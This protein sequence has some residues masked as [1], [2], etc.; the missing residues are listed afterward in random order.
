M[1]LTS[2]SFHSWEEDF[3][4]AGFSRIAGVDEVGRGCLAGPVIAASVILPLDQRI[5]GVRDSK[6]L[7]PKKRES[8]FDKILFQSLAYGIGLVE[9]A[10]ID[11]INIFQ[12]TIKA[13]L[14][15]V[16]SL[17]LPPDLVVIDG[18]ITL[19]LSIQQRS[20]IGGDD[21]CYSIAAASIVAKVTRDRLMRVMASEYPG[22]GFDRHKGYGTL[23][24]REAIKTLGVTPQHSRTFRGVC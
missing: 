13:M 14:L 22:Y 1:S 12:A 3:F 19:P 20:I 23:A 6:K 4:R 11:H 8:L 17:I 5:S 7:T 16:Q 2:H 9:V 24:H 18:N 21:L 10:E 15:S